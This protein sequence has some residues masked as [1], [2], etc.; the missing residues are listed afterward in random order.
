MN[1]GRFILLTN[2]YVIIFDKSF[3]TRHYCYIGYPLGYPLSLVPPANIPPE[4]VTPSSLPVTYSYYSALPSVPQTAQ[5]LHQTTHC[6][7]D[8]ESSGCSQ[9]QENLADMR[10]SAVNGKLIESSIL[11]AFHVFI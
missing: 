2:C 10:L 8:G 1:Y 3:Y 11:H 6:Y 7:S 5:P 4:A 9:L